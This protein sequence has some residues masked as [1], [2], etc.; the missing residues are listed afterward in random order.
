MKKLG[1][2]ASL[3]ALL[4]FSLGASPDGQPG[5]SATKAL[6]DAAED[7]VRLVLGLGVHDAAYVDAYYGPEERKSE[8]AQKALSL[9]DLRTEADRLVTQLTVLD[10]Q[11]L[12]LIDQA[13]R[14]YLKR[15]TE[16]AKARIDLVS[17]TK[18][19]FDGESQALY[20][21][22]APHYSEEHFK[23]LLGQLSEA[24]PGQGPVSERFQEFRSQFVIA[25]EKLDKVFRTA[26]KECRARTLDHVRLPKEESFTLEYVTDKPWSGYNWYQGNF[27]SL[28]QINTDLPIYIE[29]AIDLACHEGYPGHH[30][31]NMLLEQAFVVQRGWIENSVYPLFSPQSLIAEGSANYGKQIAF[32]GTERLQYESSILFPL[33]GLDASKAEQYYGILELVDQLSYAGN[34]AARQYLDGELSAEKTIAWL[35]TYSLMSHERA[36]QRLQFI[37]TYRSYVI[38]YNLGQDLVAQ[39]VEVLSGGDHDK[40]WAAFRELLSSQKLPSQLQNPGTSP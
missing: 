13:R 2:T 33:A 21:A 11:P 4:T 37:D 7:Y 27:Q 40:A 17:G 20:D 5:I 19:T 25:P 8:V 32:P 6:D 10:V 31:Y 28:I 29:R 24:L 38:N 23:K 3:S 18:F 39:H 22:Q 34:E 36:T 1:L 30:V 26:I 12:P 16:S 9:E 15:Q 14:D 35:E